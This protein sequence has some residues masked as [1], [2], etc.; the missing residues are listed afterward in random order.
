MGLL[1]DSMKVSVTQ[2]ILSC[3]TVGFGSVNEGAAGD[4]TDV[5]NHIIDHSEP[6]HLYRHISA[7]NVV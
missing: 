4:H 3:H 5:V 1:L 6:Q 2:V 7:Q